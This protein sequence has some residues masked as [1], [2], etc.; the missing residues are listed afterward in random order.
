MFISNTIKN[1]GEK[2][3][4][5]QR[6]MFDILVYLRALEGKPATLK[7]IM[8]SSGHVVEG[9]LEL[10]EAL[11]NNPKVEYIDNC[12][13]FKP[14]YN[15]KNS[16][17]ILELLSQHQNGLLVS[18]LAE[19]YTQ[20]QNDIKKLKDNK[21]IYAIKSSEGPT[22]VIFPNEEKYRM[23][24]SQELMDMWKD[25]RVPNEADLE[26]ELREA[27]LTLVESVESSKTT[28]SLQKI[29]KER[30]RRTTKLTNTHI[31]NF[32]PNAPITLPPPKE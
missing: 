31:E 7:E 21:E 23:K 11:K 8:I 14:P 32:D 6:V 20:A 5:I 22:E 29:K 19:S 9:N 28:K 13:F 17:E 16:K 26:R 2:E 25:I 12:F 3:K 24:I 15:V 18:E 4:S 10:I 1:K 30:K 27:G